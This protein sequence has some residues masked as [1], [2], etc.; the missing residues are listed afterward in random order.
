MAGIK[1]VVDSTSDIPQDIRE[2]HGIVMVPLK[3]H[4][5][6]EVYLDHVEITPAQFYRKI[7]D[8]Q[9]HPRTSQPSPG[10]FVE[11]YRRLGQDGSKILSIHLS[12]NMSGTYQS[13]VLAKSMIPEVDVE[14]M[15]SRLASMGYGV[16]AIAAARAAAE[17]KGVSE[18]ID[19][20]ER[21]RQHVHL[22]FAVDTLDYLRRNGRI[23]R[24][25][26]LLGSLLQFKPILTVDNDGFVSSYDKVRGRGR[27]L[28]RLEEIF[29]EHI[30]EGSSVVA[31]VAHA[32]ARE[33]AEKLVSGFRASYNIRE[34]VVTDLG[35]VIGTHTGPGTLACFVV[36]VSRL[37][38]WP[39]A[40]SKEVN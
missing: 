35:P 36:D 37:G 29:R 22:Y 3:V 34:T 31:V 6:P 4:F 21:V 16:M 15:D 33:D 26:H 1:V 40:P 32:G 25:Q 39:P 38:F 9:V 17:G 8:S 30:P 2:S 19:V 13:A 18:C 24:A 27:V 7:K 11:V 20:A 28:P 12:K 5:D 14:V 23:G 10:E